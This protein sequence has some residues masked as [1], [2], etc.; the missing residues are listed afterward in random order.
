MSI[1]DVV[2]ASGR[3]MPA[4]AARAALLILQHPPSRSPAKEAPGALSQGTG[5]PLSYP[6]LHKSAER[7]SASPPPLSPLPQ[8][9]AKPC[10][11][12]PVWKETALNSL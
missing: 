10:A 3:V 12:R 1:G 7:V 6:P 5:R 2:G 11:E 4:V 8:D 9:V